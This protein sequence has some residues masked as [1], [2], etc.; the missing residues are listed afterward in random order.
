MYGTPW[1]ERLHLPTGDAG[2]WATL[3]AM[4]R[5]AREG[6]QEPMVQ[7][8]AQGA[9][10]GQLETRARIYALRR[11]LDFHTR[12]THDPGE[13]EL[14]RSPTAALLEIEATG[15]LRGDCDDV[16]TLGASMALALGMTV[17]YRVLGWSRAGPYS[18]VLTECWDGRNWIDL[19]V[20]RPKQLGM[21]LPAVRESALNL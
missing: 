1:I 10:G 6:A 17:R 15:V 16:A 5:L 2:T 14:V 4:S 18:H 19:D 21:T 8:A 9:A 20:T 11:W 3:R 7:D 12:F 13:I